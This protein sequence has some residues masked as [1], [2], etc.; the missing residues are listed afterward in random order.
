MI[1]SE[2]ERRAVRRA[3]RFSSRRKHMVYDVP[4]PDVD[5]NLDAPDNVTIGDDFTIKVELKVI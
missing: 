5:F 2:E 3:F 1:G 4:K